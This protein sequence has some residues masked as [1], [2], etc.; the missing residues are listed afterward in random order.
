MNGPTLL[1][2][3]S[4]PRSR[5]SLKGFTLIELLVVI[6]IIAI[7]AGLLLPALSRAKDRA[8]LTRDISNV[9]QILVSQHMYSTDN[10]DYMPHP[11]WGGVDGTANGGPDGWG[12]AVANRGRIA[13]A[14]AYI[15]SCAGA[16]F[17]SVQFSNQ[18]KFFRISQLGPYLTTHQVLYCPKDISQMGSGK[19]KTWFTARWVKLS[20]YCFNG[21][22]GGYCGPKAGGI[23]SGKTYRTSDFIATDIILWEQNETD[24]FYFN[25]LGN[26]PETPGEIV[27]Q[28]HAGNEAYTGNVNRGGGAMVGR[29]GGHAGFIKMGQ[30]MAFVRAGSVRPNEIL[31]GPGYK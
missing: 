7:L 3:F 6:A 2:P 27:S 8:Q 26:N 20:S 5:G 23:T 19:F 4:S 21:T 9:K 12:Y 17:N 22:I 15:Q 30:F 11:T 31:N 10:N 29:V 14:P 16:G 18:V 1:P 28:R 13:D 24:G 25:D